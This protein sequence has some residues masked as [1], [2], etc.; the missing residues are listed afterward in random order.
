MAMT[1]W[2]WTAPVAKGDARRL[3][4]VIDVGERTFALLMFVALALRM[5]AAAR[6]QPFDL[7]ILLPEGLVAFFILIR[8]DAHLVSYRLVDWAAALFGTVAPMMVVPGG[9]PLAPPAIGAG[10]I[11]TGLL[12]SIGGKLSLRRSFGLA[13]ANRG[14]MQGG[15]YKIVRH[16]IYASYLLT[17]VGFMLINPT[18]WNAAVYLAAVALMAWRIRAEERVLARDPAYVA[19]M[20]RVRHRLVPGLY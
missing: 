17:Y 19:F 12:F 7:L 4:F 1:N 5:A 20:S 3:E 15:A 18:P 11:L 9:S 10:L 16:P 6:A 14:L 13:A 8:R 2:A